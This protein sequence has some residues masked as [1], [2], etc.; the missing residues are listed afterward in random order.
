MASR[1]KLAPVESTFREEG[2]GRMDR[3]RPNSIGLAG[4]LFM[5]VASAAPITAMT[6]NIPASVAIGNGVGAPA[7]YI[8]VTVILGLFSIGFVAMARHITAAGAFYGFISQGLGKVVGL[9]SGSLALVSY[10]AFYATII[11]IF[12]SFANSVF[13]DQLGVN[14]HWTAFAAVGI[15]SIG[16]LSF[17]EISLAAKV[18]GVLLIAELGILALMGVTV[19]FSG[20]GPDG[21]P[22]EPVDPSNAFQGVAPG[23]GLVFAFFSWVGF[24]STAIYG[25][26]SRNP[27]RIVPRAT[28]IAVI[29]LGLFY[30]F[31]SWMAITGTGLG[32][33]VTA[34]ETDPFQLFLGPVQQHLGTFGE[35]TYQWLLVTGSFAAALAFHN[36]AA[37][38][39]YAFG[40]EA[41][42]PRALGK[43]H[44]RH[45]SPYWANV[46]VG[47][48]CVLITLAFA[49]ENMDPYAGQYALM[50]I[51]GTLASVSALA[52]C[53]FAVI[54]YFL[55]KKRE[56]FH[57]FRTLVA[58]LTS[59]LA[60]VVVVV[61]LLENLDVAAGTA[62]STY[63]F[64]LIPW[65][66]LATFVLGA[67]LALY[68][69]AA[70]PE[71][72][73][74][75][76][77]IIFRDDGDEDAPLAPYD[78][79]QFAGSNGSEPAGQGLHKV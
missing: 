52:I 24:E 8:V 59:G 18:L 55:R 44:A 19:L 23:V 50:G 40:R 7:S 72:Y 56:D 39:L 33:S 67:A 4:V 43:T 17:F 61:L 11:G 74:R 31:V 9:A 30:A 15:L 48:S 53:S 58:P 26:E 71:I 76:G 62:S 41:F 34:S 20:G 77:R 64:Q 25:E 2:S 73:A 75:I 16:I 68:F 63:F 29:G 32:Q 37:R 36:C 78:A 60:I 54:P 47:V 1:T 70:R 13:A 22:L 10:V 51:L 49:L 45:G 28:Y 21:I 79:E 46:L 3:L 57:W 65:I 14:I 38:Y 69:R 5:V 66:V 42:V 35:D 12:A 6:G 27:R